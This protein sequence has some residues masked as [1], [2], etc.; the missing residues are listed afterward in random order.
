MLCELVIIL[1]G[2]TRPFVSRTP[3]PSTRLGMNVDGQRRLQRG[4]SS[5]VLAGTSDGLSLLDDE[6]PRQKLVSIQELEQMEMSV[7]DVPFAVHHAKL[8][9]TPGRD[10]KRT[11]S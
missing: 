5:I 2:P 8:N 7:V 4:A 3:D 11:F 10:T 1:S 9:S 6:R